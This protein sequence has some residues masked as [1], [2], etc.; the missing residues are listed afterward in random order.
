[1]NSSAIAVLL[2]VKE[3]STQRESNKE[4]N[5]RSAELQDLLFGTI[6]N[7]TMMVIKHFITNNSINIR[8]NFLL[9]DLECHVSLLAWI[10]DVVNGKRNVA[11]S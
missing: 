6:M 11:D 1:M 4:N 9:T 7:S 10:C 5:A 3:E 2:R 8:D